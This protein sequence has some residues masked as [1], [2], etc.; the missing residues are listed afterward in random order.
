MLSINKRIAELQ[1]TAGPLKLDLSK[2]EMA[3]SRSNFFYHQFD[4]YILF[5]LLR[6]TSIQNIEALC[7]VS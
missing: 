2:I 5:I 7:I 4:L 6:A 1:Q 3:V